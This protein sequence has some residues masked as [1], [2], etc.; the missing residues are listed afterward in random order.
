MTLDQKTLRKG[1]HGLEDGA[2]HA[3]AIPGTTGVAPRDDWR[4]HDARS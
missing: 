2:R 1:L 3:A 4:V